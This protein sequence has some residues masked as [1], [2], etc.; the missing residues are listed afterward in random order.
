MKSSPLALNIIIL[1]AL[2]T[3]GSCTHSE[4]GSRNLAAQDPMKACKKM[5]EDE[6]KA[7]RRFTKSNKAMGQSLVYLGEL[8]RLMRIDRNVYQRKRITMEAF[9][10]RDNDILFSW[11][12]TFGGIVLEHCYTIRED[13]TVDICTEKS[14]DTKKGYLKAAAEHNAMWRASLEEDIAKYGWN[15]PETIKTAIGAL[16]GECLVEADRMAF[17]FVRASSEFKSFVSSKCKDF[18]ESKF[19]AILKHN[20]WLSATVRDYV[21]DHC[22]GYQAPQELY[23]I[24]EKT[25]WNNE[26]MRKKVMSA[27]YYQC[28]CGP[29]IPN[30]YKSA[31]LYCGPHDRDIPESKRVHPK[32]LRVWLDPDRD[33]DPNIHQWVLKHS[34]IVDEKTRD[35]VSAEEAVQLCNDFKRKKYKGEWIK[36]FSNAEDA[37]ENL[38]L[39]IDAFELSRMDLYYETDSKTGRLK[40]DAR[41]GE[42]ILKE[43]STLEKTRREKYKNLQACIEGYTDG[44]IDIDENGNP[45]PANPPPPPPEDSENDEQ[46]KNRPKP[47]TTATPNVDQANMQ[48]T[49]KD[50]NSNVYT[51][52]ETKEPDPNVKSGAATIKGT[53]KKSDGDYDPNSTARDGKTRQKPCLP[54]DNPGGWK[55]LSEDSCAL[56]FASAVSNAYWPLEKKDLSTKDLQEMYKKERGDYITA[57]AKNQADLLAMGYV[58]AAFSQF[59]NSPAEYN[60]SL[61][62]FIKAAGNS[63]LKEHLEKVMAEEKMNPTVIGDDIKDPKFSQQRFHYET[64]GRQ[65]VDAARQ[66]HELAKYQALLRRDYGAEEVKTGAWYPK[67]ATEVYAALSLVPHFWPVA[68]FLYYTG[69]EA[70]WIDFGNH[71]KYQCNMFDMMFTSNW[72]PTT[73]SLIQLTDRKI[74]S[75]YGNQKSRETAFCQKDEHGNVTSCTVP[76]EFER[77]ISQSSPESLDKS[78]VRAHNL[79]KYKEYLA[80]AEKR[81]DAEAVKRY[82]RKI[83]FAAMTLKEIEKRHNEIYT[84]AIKVINR[85]GL[86]N[87]GADAEK[88]LPERIAALEAVENR[89]SDQNKELERRRGELALVDEFEG[90][91]E[92]ISYFSI[93]LRDWCQNRTDAKR[94]LESASN[95][96][97]ALYPALAHIDEIKDK[98]RR[99]RPYAEELYEYVKKVDNDPR[100]TKEE[101]DKKYE[102]LA[103]SAAAKAAKVLPVVKENLKKYLA[104]VA[105]LENESAYQAILNGSMAAGF[106][107][108]KD[109]K[110]SKNGMPCYQRDFYISCR[111]NKEAQDWYQEQR[112]PAFYQQLGMSLLDAVPVLGAASGALRFA[113]TAKG[114]AI[115]AATGLAI[116]GANYAWSDYI[117]RNN[118]GRWVDYHNA[119]AA[120]ALN[121][122]DSYTVALETMAAANPEWRTRDFV[123]GFIL[124]ATGSGIITGKKGVSARRT[125]VPEGVLRDVASKVGD[126]MEGKITRQDLNDYLI[127]QSGEH[128]GLLEHLP[129]RLADELATMT[130]NVYAMKFDGA[131]GAR[132]A[133][134]ARHTMGHWMTLNAQK[135]FKMLEGFK[136]KLSAEQAAGRVLN[137]VEDTLAKTNMEVIDLAKL[138]DALGPREVAMLA[139]DL[140]ELA[141][142][143]VADKPAKQMKRLS[144]FMKKICLAASACTSLQ[145]L[146]GCPR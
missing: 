137:S 53:G 94:G 73:D 24:Y 41:T 93:Q 38:Y 75:M 96:L 88:W 91:R 48:S 6:V 108:C 111:M 56:N 103:R 72:R 19:K 84:S 101:K 50:Q 3:L 105:R 106:E 11:I 145:G 81:G 126:F 35:W 64:L 132:A 32:D 63:V 133:A 28:H 1:V 17:E 8:S 85:I 140:D 29:Y 92:E 69:G 131:D 79:R 104:K 13:Q 16:H 146:R 30:A 142:S 110:E 57:L 66:I 95:Q 128:G 36:D 25:G 62:E 127:K 114:I 80:D 141:R 20:R 14:L 120:M 117:A 4:T 61:D 112:L 10:S 31:K 134:K 86:D 18:S 118:E 125:N 77:Y 99:G 130:D 102:A 78:K 76:W 71:G 33:N 74:A 37:I 39:C 87:K 27:K 47:Q 43:S 26:T 15:H 107:Y 138:A 98:K 122:I 129:R 55:C 144:E 82:K 70:M 100:L 49:G 40:R 136:S 83:R 115:G 58:T 97:A 121:G 9:L 67:M 54:G 68:A 7:F 135:V 143:I 109:K 46:S 65:M 124:G 22:G 113:F 123:L 44:K 5:R 90:L 139:K 119:T 59:Y 34:G 51:T 89:S 21:A 60:Q 116:T 45:K 12:D 52:R 2:I 42:H 23:E